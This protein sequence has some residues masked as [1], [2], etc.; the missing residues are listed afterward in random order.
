MRRENLVVEQMNGVRPVEGVN[1]VAA[2]CVRLARV[3]QTDPPAL[4]FLI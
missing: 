3:V 1:V 2:E 4:G